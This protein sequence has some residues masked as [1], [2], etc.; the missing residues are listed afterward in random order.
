MEQG[1]LHPVRE[2]GVCPESGQEPLWSKQGY[3]GSGGRFMP[4]KGHDRGPRLAPLVGRV[5]LE[6]GVVSSSPM[7]G[8]ESTFKKFLKT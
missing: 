7:L 8:A 3:G 4:L 1:L 5:T 6:R 2:R